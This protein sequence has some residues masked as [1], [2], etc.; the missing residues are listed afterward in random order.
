LQI[1]MSFTLGWFAQNVTLPIAFLI[2][3]AIYGG[4][5]VAALRVR[6]LSVPAKGVPEPTAG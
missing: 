6:A 4:G 3:G 5:V 1:M 2:L